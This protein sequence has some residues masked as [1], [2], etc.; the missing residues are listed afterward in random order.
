MKSKL[1]YVKIIRLPRF[2]DVCPHSSKNTADN[3]EGIY[4]TTSS[5]FWPKCFMGIF[6]CY[7]PKNNHHR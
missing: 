2:T 3:I 4:S 6:T 5:S 7:C 1:H